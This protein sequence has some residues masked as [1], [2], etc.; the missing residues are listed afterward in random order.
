[1]F[2]SF[3]NISLTMQISVI[4]T[5]R[6]FEC[7]AIGNTVFEKANWSNMLFWSSISSQK[8]DAKTTPIKALAHRDLFKHKK[9]DT[10]Q[11]YVNKQKHK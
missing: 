11:P 7:A 6:H 9:E 1:M 2:F 5:N 4:N 3:A 10:Y 8:P